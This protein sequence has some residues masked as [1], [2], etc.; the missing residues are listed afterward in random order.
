MIPFEYRV[1]ETAQVGV[2]TGYELNSRS[3]IPGRGKLLLFSI[4]FK[5]DSEAHTVS[6]SMDTGGC[7]L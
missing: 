4:S 1:V 2:A 5:T 6:C 7:F 3:L